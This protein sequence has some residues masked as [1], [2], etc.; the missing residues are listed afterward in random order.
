MNPDR[1]ELVIHKIRTASTHEKSAVP[2]GLSEKISSIKKAFQDY[3]RTEHLPLAGS[4]VNVISEGIPTPVLTVCGRGTQEIR[5]TS[6]LA[7]FLDPQKDHGLGTSLLKSVFD[8]EAREFGLIENWADDCT[9]TPEYRIGNLPAKGGT[10]KACFCDIGIIGSSFVFVI[11]QKILSGEGMSAHTGMKQLN[12]YS[13]A[14]EINP[15]FKGKKVIKIYLTPSGKVNERAVDW[16]PMSHLDIIER[17]R[18]C[19]ANRI[20]SE[21]A[22]ENLHRLLIDLSLGPYEETEE[23]ISEMKD[24]ALSLTGDPVGLYEVVKFRRLVDD[25]R[26]LVNILLE[27]S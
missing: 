13:K 22:R 2:P 9:V 7:Y 4:I 8:Q 25:N 12:G 21:T 24:A 14:I 6:Y 19:L 16:L 23:L 3:W 5:F 1:L 20:I 17:A 26:L 11:E 15:F 10:E 18:R 27:G